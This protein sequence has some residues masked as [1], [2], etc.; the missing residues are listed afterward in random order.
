MLV[1]NSGDVSLDGASFSECTSGE[2][3]LPRPHTLACPAHARTPS[4]RRRREKKGEGH[5]VANGARLPQKVAQGLPALS[6]LL[7]PSPLTPARPNSRS[8][9]EL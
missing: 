6:R 2:V 5:G 7:T 1:W 9:E 3:R 4:P 8:S